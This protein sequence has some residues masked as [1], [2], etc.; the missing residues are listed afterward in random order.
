[1]GIRRVIFSFLVGLVAAVC[2]ACIWDVDTERQEEYFRGY[3]SAV[4]DAMTGHFLRFPPE[5]YRSRISVLEARPNLSL[6]EIDDLAVAHDRLGE[7]ET[8]IKIIRQKAHLEG[9]ENHDAYRYH[10]NL[11]TFLAHAW[12]KKPDRFQNLD[13]LKQGKSHIDRAIEINP[14]AHFGREFAQ[15]DLMAWVIQVS[16][17]R[18]DTTTL[19]EFMRR[20]ERDNADRSPTSLYG[21]PNPVDAKLGLAGLVMLGN[22]WQSPDLALTLAVLST[23]PKDKGVACARFLD[24]QKAG[25]PGIREDLWPAQIKQLEAIKVDSSLMREGMNK[26]Y[27]AR[28]EKAEEE[29]AARDA[30][31]MEKIQESDPYTDPEF[32]KDYTGDRPFHFLEE[33]PDFQLPPDEAAK[34]RQRSFLPLY[35]MVGGGVVV[36]GI[37]LFV[38]VKVGTALLGRLRNGISR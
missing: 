36:G 1:M 13:L 33:S 3:G 30:Y 10:A 18:E 24:L 38:L 17:N 4:Q 32:W 21:N 14:G 5:Y 12:L 2:L 35:L 22:G 7:S 15:R 19:A 20:R 9:Q 6:N 27:P 29:S 11:G 28:L 34:A 8:A 16:E 25:R 37:L 23:D 31:F 26:T